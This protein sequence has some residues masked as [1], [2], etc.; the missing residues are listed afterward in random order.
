MMAALLCM[1]WLPDVDSFVMLMNSATK[2]MMVHTAVIVCATTFPLLI[3]V[4]PTV[5]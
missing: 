5:V 1:G 2:Q 3:T 4:F